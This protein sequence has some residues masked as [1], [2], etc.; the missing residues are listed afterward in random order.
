MFNFIHRIWQNFYYG[1]L[2][3]A[4]D[5]DFSAIPQNITLQSHYDAVNKV[6]WVE[7]KE[8]PDFEATGKNLEELAEH[9]GDSLLVYLDIPYFFAKNYVDGE[10][11]MTDPITGN[12]ETIKVSRKS[13]ERVLA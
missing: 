5:V 11:I 9:I 8:L 4:S 1:Y 7:S 12:H 6:Y 10:L 3:H 13:V 2:G